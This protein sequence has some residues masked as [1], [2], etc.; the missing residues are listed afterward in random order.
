MFSNSTSCLCAV[1]SKVL[2]SVGL[3]NMVGRD[4]RKL[5]L[6]R[7]SK[8]SQY[9]TFT[10]SG[11]FIFLVTL[12]FRLGSPKLI[13]KGG[14]RCSPHKIRFPLHTVWRIQSKREHCISFWR[15]EKN[16]GPSA[17]AELVKAKSKKFST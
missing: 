17:Q 3:E 15:R 7:I 13:L 16:I 14:G 12:L 2:T 6:F 1:P 11:L 8:A 5:S 10:C 9:G 4:G